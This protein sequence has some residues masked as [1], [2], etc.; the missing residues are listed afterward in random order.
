MP[1]SHSRPPASPP[2]TSSLRA[3]NYGGRARRLVKTFVDE[4][5]RSTV[6]EA[7]HRRRSGEVGRRI[8]LVHV[9]AAGATTLS[10]LR[11]HARLR[12]G[13][14]AQAAPPSPTALTPEEITEKLNGVPVFCILN[15]D[16]GVVSMKDP[17]GGDAESVY[18]SDVLRFINEA[19][20]K[21]DHIT[22]I[23]AD[24][25]ERMDR[26]GD[27]KIQLEELKHDAAR[28]PTLYTVLLGLEPVFP[29]T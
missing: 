29:H 18:L 1:T 16:G 26:D 23:A 15:K 28:N 6:T 20:A 27:G 13:A 5:I 12:G 17:E 11:P 14:E 8:L 25:I 3:E 10:T 9:L 22:E 19:S 7:E 24:M 4:L 21:L 2:T